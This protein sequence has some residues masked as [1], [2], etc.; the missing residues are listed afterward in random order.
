VVVAAFVTI[1]D[2]V[3]HAFTP[4]LY[5]SLGLFIPLIVVN[6]IV[7]GRA[8]AY[9]SKRPVLDSLLDGLGMGTGYALAI[10]LIGTIREIL[11]NGTWFGMSLFGDSFLPMLV[12]VLPPGAF[13]TLGFIIAGMNRL[14][15]KA[16]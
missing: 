10:V 15:A 5:K 11:G 14:A 12:M 8:E 2:L 13:F 9:A 16:S 6:C 7:L 3:M 1:V 4:G